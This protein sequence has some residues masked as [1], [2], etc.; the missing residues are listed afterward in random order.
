MIPMEITRL[1]VGS[2][3]ISGGCD[4]KTGY[5]GPS[6]AKSCHAGRAVVG[7]NVLRPTART[8]S[9]P[10][11]RS[12]HLTCNRVGA[13]HDRREDAVDLLEFLEEPRP[14]RNAHVAHEIGI[15]AA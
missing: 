6:G 12:A 9:I 8:R 14:D 2:R 13:V 5:C 4:N 7:R 15:G 1:Q 11:D 10:I 3:Y